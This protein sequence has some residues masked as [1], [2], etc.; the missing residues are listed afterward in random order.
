LLLGSEADARNEEPPA[1][2][3]PLRPAAEERLTTLKTRARMNTQPTPPT[4]L[5]LRELTWSVRVMI[6]AQLQRLL[7]ATFENPGARR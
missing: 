6:V 3:A 7:D 4:E 2:E 5:V 1:G